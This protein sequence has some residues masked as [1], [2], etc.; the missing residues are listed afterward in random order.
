MIQ[1][2]AS[3]LQFIVISTPSFLSTFLITFAKCG[4]LLFFCTHFRSINTSFISLSDDP[5]FIKTFKYLKS[6]GYPALGAFL[7]IA[8]LPFFTLILGSS[9]SVWGVVISVSDGLSM[10]LFGASEPLLRALDRPPILIYK[11]LWVDA[12]LLDSPEPM[13]DSA[14][15]RGSGRILVYFSTTSLLTLSQGL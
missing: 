14:Q 2:K 3:A 8:I 5:F 7:S 6:N 9:L 10:G 12:P 11:G 15:R 1:L 4:T 13:L